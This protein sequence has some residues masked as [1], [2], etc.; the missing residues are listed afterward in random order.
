MSAESDYTGFIRWLLGSS[1]AAWIAFDVDAYLS[2]EKD[3]YWTVTRRAHQGDVAVGDRVFL[4]RARGSSDKTPGV[5]AGEAVL[6][7]QVPGGGS[8]EWPEH[9]IGS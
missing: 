9:P 2:A 3:I 4:W 1:R 5:V 8:Q 7:E 6:L